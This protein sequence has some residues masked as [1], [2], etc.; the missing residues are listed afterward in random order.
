MSST[1]ESEMRREILSN[2]TSRVTILGDLQRSKRTL[3][4]LPQTDPPTEG[5]LAGRTVTFGREGTAWRGTLEGGEASEEQQLE[6]EALA[7]KLGNEEA[8]AMFG[9]EP[10][11]V[12]D[13]WEIDPSNASILTTGGEFTGSYLLRFERVEEYEGL[14]CAVLEGTIDVSRRTVDR[15][16]GEDSGM[17]INARASIYRS[18][19]HLENLK[20]EI[21]GNLVMSESP[22]LGGSRLVRGPLRISKSVKLTLP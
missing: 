16:G 7:A 14:R 8:V 21:V 2:Q 9:T 18:L 13:E 1:H 17:R 4:G 5:A 6:I 3:G 15:L 11:R 12:G 19:D 10:R 22:P 20:S